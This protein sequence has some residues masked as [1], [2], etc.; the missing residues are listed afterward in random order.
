MTQDEAKR[1]F[2]DGVPV[3]YENPQKFRGEIECRFIQELVV[4][5]GKDG[6]ATFLVGA[7]DRKRNAIYH[8]VP[9]HFRLKQ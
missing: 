2:A 7:L 5:R 9:G 1:A 8:D 4:R 3:I 6:K